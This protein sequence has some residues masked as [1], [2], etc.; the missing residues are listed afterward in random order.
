VALCLLFLLWLPSGIGM[1]YWGM[2]AVT[3]QDRLSDCIH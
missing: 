1:M 2:P 3:S